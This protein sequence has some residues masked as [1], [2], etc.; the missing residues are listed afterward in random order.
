[1]RRRDFL[2]LSGSTGLFLFFAA[3]GAFSQETER[4]RRRPGYPTD[5]NAYLKISPDNR[6]GCY[7]G[8]VELGQ[9]AMTSL[10]MLAAEELDVSLDRVEMV[11]SDTLS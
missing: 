6:V 5:F 1:M 9:G 8:K 2:Q 4:V 7:V 3:R 10:A 11:P